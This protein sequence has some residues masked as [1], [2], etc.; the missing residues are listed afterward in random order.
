M[1]EKRKGME[2]TRK[3]EKDE[4]VIDAKIPFSMCVCVRSRKEGRKE[5]GT[6]IVKGVV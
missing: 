6:K 3:S 4:S 1:G 2:R 5:R